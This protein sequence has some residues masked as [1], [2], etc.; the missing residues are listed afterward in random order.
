MKLYL[1]NY[2]ATFSFGKIVEVTHQL[3]VFDTSESNANTKKEEN[4]MRQKHMNRA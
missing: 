1:G 4:D 3:Q 2:L